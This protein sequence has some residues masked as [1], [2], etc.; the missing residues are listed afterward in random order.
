MKVDRITKAAL[1]V[2]AVLFSLNLVHNLIGSK[3]A[4]AARGSEVHRE[5]SN[6][7]V[8]SAG[9]GIYAS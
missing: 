8:G 5:I 1:W 6:S 4:M 2:I 9:W 3:P 7:R